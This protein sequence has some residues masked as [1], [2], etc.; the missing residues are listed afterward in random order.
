MKEATKSQKEDVGVLLRLVKTDSAPGRLGRSDELLDRFEDH[1]V[2]TRDLPV[3]RPHHH[4]TNAVYPA[5]SHHA[6]LLV[7]F[8]LKRLDLAGEI[9]VCV[10][11]PAE[12]HKGAHDRDIYFDGTRAAQ[13][14]GKLAT[15]CSVKA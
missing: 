13:H 7:V 5:A 10:H 14:A 3:A 9:A 15:P 6:V 11:E 2:L 12:L 1:R 4:A 8:L